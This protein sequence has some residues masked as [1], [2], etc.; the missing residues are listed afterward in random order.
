MKT[1][2]LGFLLEFTIICSMSL[3]ALYC[4]YLI[5]IELGINYDLQSLL[6]L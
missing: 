6:N 3:A 2:L 1:K 5:L 4:L